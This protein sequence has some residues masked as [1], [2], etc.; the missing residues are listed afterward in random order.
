MSLVLA[1]LLGALFLL[2]ATPAEAQTVWSATFTPAAGSGF[3]GCATKNDCDSQFSDNSFTVGGTDYHFTAFFRQSTQTDRLRILLNAGANSALQALKL[4]VGSTEYALS[5]VGIGVTGYTTDPGFSAGDSVS[6]SI[7]SSCAPTPSYTLSVTATPACGSEVSDMSVQPRWQLK[8][9][10]APETERAVDYSPVDSSG[11]LLGGEPKWNG[12]LPVSPQYGGNSIESPRDRPFAHFRVAFPGFAGFKFRLRDDHSIEESCTWQFDDDGGGTQPDTQPTPDTG[13]TNTGG[14]GDG[15][16]GGGGGGSGG[17]GGTPPSSE[18]SPLP[19][20]PLPQDPDQLD[21]CGDDDR[22]NLVR[23]YEA[24]RGDGWTENEN[25][26]SPELLDQWFGVETDE[27]GRVVSLRLSENNLSGDMPVEFLLCLSE[28]K[29]LALWGNE[30][31][32]GEVPEELVL[33]VERA[34]LRDIAEMLDLNPEWF[35]D[36]ED[37]FDFED[38]HPG[39][40]TDEEGRVTELDLTGEGVLGEIPESVSELRRL[41]EI[42]TTR[43]S[44]D[45]GCVLSPEDS[46]AFSLF[47]LTLAV[48]AVLVRRRG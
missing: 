15:S 10:P 19:E 26:N 17:G 45:G 36:Y 35:E 4:C 31:L 25:W 29:E 42:M 11:G 30:D 37:P 23:F 16:D 39:V 13:G 41:R 38:W 12:H 48:F 20:E 40:T 9:T 14:G 18:D 28:L 47:L 22:E 3:I 24:L 34:V 2:N 27:D 1:L 32:S 43:S 46:S 7:G 33:R 6:V 5:E 21:D 8:L 44:S